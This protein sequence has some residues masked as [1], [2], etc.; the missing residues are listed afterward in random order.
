MPL[1]HTKASVF[2]TPTNVMALGHPFV[3]PAHNDTPGVP[4]GIDPLSH[5]LV[6]FD[7]WKLMEAKVLNSI[8]G[9]FL[10]LIRHGKS[11][12]MKILA[13]RLMMIAAG[14]DMMRILIN[15]YKPEDAGSEYQAMTKLTRSKLFAVANSGINP[16]EA[17]LYF[18]KDKG[19]YELGMLGMAEMLAEFA[20]G[21]KL[22]GNNGTALRVAM[23][24]MLRT[25]PSNWLLSSLHKHLLSITAPKVRAYR[26]NLDTK[27]KTQLEERLTH[28]TDPI[29]RI[30]AEQDIR[31]LVAAASNDNI[32]EI[33]AAGVYVASLLERMLFG[34]YGGMFGTNSLY[35]MLTQ[36]A[37]TLDWRGAQG[38]AETVGRL[39]LTHVKMSAIEQNL[40]ALIPHIEL[41]DEKHKSMDNLLYAQTNAFAGEI[42]RGI[43]TCNLSATHRLAS[44]RK[45][46]VGSPLYAAGQTII[47]N[48]GFA[49]IGRQEDDNETLDELQQQYMLS[50][51][52]TRQLTTMPDYTFLLKL[53][54]AEPARFVRI[55]ATPLEMEH[56]LKTGAATERMTTRPDIYNDHDLERFAA[57]NGVVYLGADAMGEPVL[58]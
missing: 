25:S 13:I 5:E 16:F 23:H 47:R 18:T 51:W 57:Q 50:N 36:R 2:S 12:A 22:I 28:I 10:G 49:W 14:F 41:D 21:E 35:S 32:Q 39:L 19:V 9:I 44:I 43:H 52:Q 40:L 33:Q 55:F 8:F 4:V 11:S 1:S 48:Q 34:A 30:A 26:N 42:S 38:E 56:I 29:M 24:A 54:Q 45:G 6:V 15:D 37:V 46:G 3:S 7:P 31:N 53:G 20:N 27:L 17:N 58:V